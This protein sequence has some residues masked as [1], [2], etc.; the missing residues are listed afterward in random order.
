[1]TEN[2]WL[3]SAHPASMLALLSSKASDRKFR[4]FACA[5]CRHIWHL[6]P[7]EEW[8]VAVETAERYA[9]GEASVEE[10][11]TAE[12]NVSVDEV[13]CPSVAVLYTCATDLPA[14]DIARYV[15]ENAA[16]GAEDAAF[17]A[18]VTLQD[19]E[20]VAGYIDAVATEPSAQARLVRDIFGNPFRPVAIT[21]DWL[22]WEYGAVPMLASQIYAARAFDRLPALANV[23]QQAGCDNPD[24]LDHC[25][26]GGEHALGCWV[27]DALLSKN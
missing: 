12:A 3:N 19:E 15:S 14:Y 22:S 2:E 13:Y 24:I 7:N 11:R 5:C 23:L 16:S 6:L 8:Q 1:M 25:R 18:T 4:L 17:D 20:L 27:V 10:L 26:S 21:P 9:D